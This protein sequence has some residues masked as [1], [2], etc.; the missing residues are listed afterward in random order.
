MSF[1]AQ[2]ERALTGCGWR[3]SEMENGQAVFSKGPHVCLTVGEAANAQLA[4][5]AGLGWSEL[6]APEG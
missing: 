3:R 5:D 1:T 2:V 6:D 4:M